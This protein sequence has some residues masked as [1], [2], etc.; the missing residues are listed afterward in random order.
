QHTALTAHD[1]I[2]L[3]EIVGKMVMTA[4]NFAHPGEQGESR[5]LSLREIADS[6]GVSHTAV[7]KYA[8]ALPS[9]LGSEGKQGRTYQYTLADATELRGLMG[10]NQTR[11]AGEPCVT[12]GVMNF[13]GGVAKSTTTAHLSQNLALRGFRT[14]AID[15]DPQG[16]LSTLFGIHP[17]VDLDADDTLLPYFE[18]K[19]PTLDYCI[20]NTEIPTLRVIPANVGLAQ[21]DLVLPARQRD[22][23][24]NGNSEW[25]Y[26][27]SLAEGIRTIE[28]DFDVILLDCPPS[29]SYLTT[30]AT[31]ACDSLLMPMRPSMP[32]F[33]SSAQFIRMFSSFQGDVDSILETTKKFDWLRVLITLGEHNN[34]SSEMEDIIRKAYGPMVMLER[35]PYLTAVATA[36]KRMRTLYDVSRAD[37]DS[38]QL[39]KALNL[40]DQMCGAVEGLILGTR[41]RLATPG[42]TIGEA[43]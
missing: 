11:G 39:G 18:G 17:D 42:L 31:Q 13:K 33:A 36:A 28:N 5:R 1:L 38:R 21:A 19:E 29:M 27:T 7:N 8:A 26:M 16:T 15:C 10:L 32:D 35:F 22:E 9:R 12:L 25:F 6:L 23:R 24:S 20:R 30:V 41:S 3:G 4:K 14:L 43:A 40:V 34:T 37:I 2:G